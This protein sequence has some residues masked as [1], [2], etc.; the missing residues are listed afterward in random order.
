MIDIIAIGHSTIRTTSWV[1]SGLVRGPKALR[2][3]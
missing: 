1:L 2:R 3:S